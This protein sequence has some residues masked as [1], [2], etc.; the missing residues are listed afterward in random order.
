MNDV[1]VYKGLNG[2]EEGKWVRLFHVPLAAIDTQLDP[3]DK[4]QFVRRAEK[5]TTLGDVIDCS[6]DLSLKREGQ[7]GKDEVKKAFFE[8]YSKQRGGKKHA[9]D[10]PSVIENARVKIELD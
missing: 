4:K 5:Y 9:Q 10:R 7:T 6:K 8:D 3:H 2:D 1:K